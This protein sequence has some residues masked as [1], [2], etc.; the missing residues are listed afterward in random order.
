MAWKRDT[1][2][3]GKMNVINAHLAKQKQVHENENNFP[4]MGTQTKIENKQ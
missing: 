1:K 3:K 4:A 2:G